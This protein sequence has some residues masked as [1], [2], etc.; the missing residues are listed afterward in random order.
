MIAN[1]KQDL[2][3]TSGYAC[4]L[5]LT[6]PGESSVVV[7]QQQREASSHPRASDAEKV[8]SVAGERFQQ[9]QKEIKEQETLLRGYQQVSSGIHS[10]LKLFTVLCTITTISNHHLSQLSHNIEQK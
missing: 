3:G 2:F 8:G 1:M 6:G 10:G 4:C 7:L 9:M 5:S